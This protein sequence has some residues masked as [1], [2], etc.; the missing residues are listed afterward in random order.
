M[1]NDD[2]LTYSQRVFSAYE[3]LA[4]AMKTPDVPIHALHRRVGGSLLDLQNH[5]RAECLAHRA[6]PSTGEPVFAG[7]AARQSA[8]TIRGEVDRATGKPQ[9]FLLIKLI[10]PPTMT[11]EQPPPQAKQHPKITLTL[12]VNQAELV[13]EAL[14]YGAYELEQYADGHGRN[15]DGVETHCDY[16]SDLEKGLLAFVENPKG[17]AGELLRDQPAELP[18]QAKYEKLL[19]ETAALRYPYPERTAELEARIEKTIARKVGE[20]TQERQAKQYEVSLRRQ[21]AEKRPNLTPQEREHYEQRIARLVAD[22][23][24][25]QQ[26]QPPTPQPQ[27]PPHEQALEQPQ[28]QPARK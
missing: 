28:R 26:Q 21:L 5:L 25:A 3:S 23:R 2:P 16:L 1:S 8:L 19:R 6:T 18:A 20:F 11:Q 22:Y 13:A 10:D 17:R 7:D 4:D 15:I 27:S 24:Q 9:L 12:N 14:H